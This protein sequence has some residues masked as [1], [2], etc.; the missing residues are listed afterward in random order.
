M[1]LSIRPT[2]TT[3]KNGPHAFAIFSI[4]GSTHLQMY[5]FLGLVCILLPTKKISILATCH[6]S[7]P[8][9]NLHIFFRFRKIFELIAKMDKNACTVCTYVRTYSLKAFQFNSNINLVTFLRLTAREIVIFST[10]RE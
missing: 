6:L 4:F 7:L 9:I 8:I 5:L 10:L 1:I 3:S 2:T